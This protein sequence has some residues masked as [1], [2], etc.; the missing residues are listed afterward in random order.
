MTLKNGK[1]LWKPV[2]FGKNWGR[3]GRSGFACA[4][5]FS[6]LIP[7][8]SLLARVPDNPTQISKAGWGEWKPLSE[9]STASF[10]A[11][12]SNRELGG[13]LDFQNACQEATGKPEDAIN[14][15]FRLNRLVE[16]IGTGTVEYGCWQ[17][18][19]FLSTFTSTAIRTDIETVD[20]LEVNSAQG[21]GL[22][23]RDEPKTASQRLGV[24]VNGSTVHPRNF[25]ALIVHRQQRDWL[26]IEQP[27]TGW[28]SI[29]IVP[30]EFLNLKLCQ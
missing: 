23:V 9:V 8:T 10:T 24:V 27:I 30:E 25:P 2:I 19:E 5:A 28:V 29:G 11:G 3:M 17:D 13:Y 14:Y 21:N 22:V 4:I 26:R 16:A 6:L 15:W 12:F 7:Q 1:P 18:G 20:C